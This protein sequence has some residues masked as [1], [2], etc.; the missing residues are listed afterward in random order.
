M[1]YFYSAQAN[2]FYVSGIHETMPDDVV[3]I[4]DQ[5]HAEL[6][7]AQAAGKVITADND[8]EPVA[9]DPPPPTPE[10]L[11]AMYANAVQA[12]LDS[13]AKA[14]GYDNIASAA[15][16]ATEPAVAKFQA[17][18]QAFRAWRSLCWAYCYEQLA[19]VENEERELPSVQDFIEELPVLSLP[20]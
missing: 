19:L 10:Q 16:Y 12:H 11:V 7:A 3:E 1:P 2:S 15:S 8:G 4:T 13:A 17:E 20:V 14:A 5:E 9:I 18:G 6:L